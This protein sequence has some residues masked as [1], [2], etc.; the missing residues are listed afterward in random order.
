MIAREAIASLG[1]PRTPRGTRETGPPP[2][3]TGRIGFRRDESR[4]VVAALQSRYADETGIKTLKIRHNNVLGYFVDV[5]AQH[6]DKFMSAPLNSTFI[7]RQTLAGQVRF[8][9]T[10]LGELEAKIA[11][12][13]DRALNLELEIF[14][15]LAAAVIADGDGIKAAADALAALDAASALAALAGSLLSRLP[16]NLWLRLPL[17]LLVLLIAIAVL[18]LR[19]MA[20]DAQTGRRIGNALAVRLRYVTVFTAIW[21]NSNIP[22]TTDR[23]RNLFISIF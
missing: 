8:T 19:S 1:P 16:I 7:H 15:R 21:I 3:E 17:T 4:R 2:D 9:T 20:A 23:S 14:E 10:E 12:A 22:T 13:A 6:G 11:N 5:T 18:V